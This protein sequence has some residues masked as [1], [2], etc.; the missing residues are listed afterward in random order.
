MRTEC[1][2]ALEVGD[3]TLFH[4]EAL[5]ADLVSCLALAGGP[6]ANVLNKNT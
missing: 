3:P 6:L 1:A 4:S 2:W 5:G